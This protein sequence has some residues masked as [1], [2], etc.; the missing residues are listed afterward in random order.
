V[1]AAA[2]LR[3]GVPV[4]AGGAEIGRIGSVA[5]TRGLA[6][7]RLDRAGEA[8]AKGQPLLA[9]EI[10]IVLRNP[11]WASFDLAPAAPTAAGKG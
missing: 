11:A 8:I 6:L 1:E 3:A 10:A 9:G 4:M 7:V 2:P 5:G